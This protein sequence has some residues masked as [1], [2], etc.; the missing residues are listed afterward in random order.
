[1]LGRTGFRATGSVG[2]F[3]PLTRRSIGRQVGD[4]LDFDARAERQTAGGDRAPGR[5]VSG[6]VGAINLVERRPVGEVGEEDGAP[7]QVGHR[8]AVPPGD[9]AHVLHR[10]QRLL[11]NPAGDHPA[12]AGDV[13]HLAGEEEELAGTNRF[14]PV[15]GDRSR[16]VRVRL[17][18][19]SGTAQAA[20]LRYRPGI[21]IAVV[22]DPLRLGDEPHRLRIIDALLESATYVVRLQG[23]GGRAYRLKIDLP[24]A[25]AGLDGAR[26]IDREGS[27]RTLEV[28]LLGGPRTWSDATVRV[29]LGAREK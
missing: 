16:G 10:L 3:R 9:G 8:R 2:P 15:P 18:T 7:D 24:F 17:E 12:L 14:V 29:R 25:L 27:V 21:E 1:M 13:A 26:E 20:Q 22:N 19:D 4:A 11:P 23:R 28:V 6:E 5:E